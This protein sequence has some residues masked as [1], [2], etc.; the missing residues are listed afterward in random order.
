MTAVCARMQ[1]LGEP[2]LTLEA[3]IEAKSFYP[4]MAMT[5]N[6]GDAQAALAAAKN[7]IRGAR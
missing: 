2:I 4:S 7:V 5:R 6:V 3:G 1:E